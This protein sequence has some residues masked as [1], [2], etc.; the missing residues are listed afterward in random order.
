MCQ[1]FLSG[2]IYWASKL[3]AY[4]AHEDTIFKPILCP[5]IL[6]YMLQLLAYAAERGQIIPRDVQHTV[7]SIFFQHDLL[8][9][10]LMQ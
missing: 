1:L 3:Y 2:I 6:E 4:D 8:S 7:V 5:E 9:P 10:T